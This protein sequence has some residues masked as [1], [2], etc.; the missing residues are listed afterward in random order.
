[1]DVAIN[2]YHNYVYNVPVTDWYYGEASF[3]YFI[4]SN[5]G[6]EDSV[7]CIPKQVF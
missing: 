7:G 3:D 2:Q 6:Y 1:M 5:A 4:N